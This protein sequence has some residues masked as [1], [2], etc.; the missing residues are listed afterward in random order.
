MH[1]LLAQVYLSPGPTELYKSM[2]PSERIEEQL[3]YVPATYRCTGKLRQAD[4]FPFDEKALQP[5]LEEKT[6][7]EVTSLMQNNNRAKELGLVLHTL[8][9]PGFRRR[10]NTIGNPLLTKT[11][12][13]LTYAVKTESEYGSY[14]SAEEIFKLAWERESGL[15]DGSITPI[16]DL[17][18]KD[19]NERTPDENGWLMWAI[20]LLLLNAPSATKGK[21]YLDLFLSRKDMQDINKVREKQWKW[22]LALPTTRARAYYCYVLARDGKREEANSMLASIMDPQLMR[23]GHTRRRMTA[24]L[25]SNHSYNHRFGSEVFQSGNAKKYVRSLLQPHCCE[26]AVDK[27]IRAAEQT[28]MAGYAGEFSAAIRSYQRLLVSLSCFQKLR[29]DDV[30]LWLGEIGSILLLISPSSQNF[31]QVLQLMVEKKVPIL[32]VDISC[33]KI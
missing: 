25:D 8:V 9:F 1:N 3:V 21:Y 15:R 27:S 12:K 22:D 23:V 10:R 32:N 20:H 4:S 17:K 24:V 29:K 28:L 30:M 6:Y 11:L 18:N 19:E 16:Y 7:R 26:T 14:T 31:L 5:H 2:S 33:A 13:A